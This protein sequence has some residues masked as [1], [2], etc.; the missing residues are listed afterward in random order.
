MVSCAKALQPE[1]RQLDLVCRWGRP[2]ENLGISEIMEFSL[3][4]TRATLILWWHQLKPQARRM[5]H[6]GGE[7][8]FLQ[9][10]LASVDFWSS[11]SA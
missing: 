2:E 10:V 3:D 4:K 5:F 1:R 11:S 9:T 6:F 8:C 7:S